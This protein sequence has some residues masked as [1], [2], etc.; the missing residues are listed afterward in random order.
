MLCIEQINIS[1]IK[2]AKNN[3]LLY[4]PTKTVLVTVML[5]LVLTGCIRQQSENVN[6]PVDGMVTNQGYEV[7]LSNDQLS[8]SGMLNG[9]VL[10]ITMSNKS[11]TDIVID[12][13]FVFFVDITAYNDKDEMIQFDYKDSFVCNQKDS[14]AFVLSPNK[15]FERTIDFTKSFVTLSF[16]TGHYFDREPTS[17]IINVFE[18]SLVL[19]KNTII[20]KIKLEYAMKADY[21][22]TVPFYLGIKPDALGYFT[23][24]CSIIIHQSKLY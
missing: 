12:K 15:K 3:V 16:A 8:L 13:N 23:K 5:I 1:C 7:L 22:W 18:E 20:S 17:Q 9:N 6:N 21:Q 19:P 11:D 4:S 24:P 2:P 14:R 10:S